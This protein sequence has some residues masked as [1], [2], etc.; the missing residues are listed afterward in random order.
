MPAGLVI[1][2][3]HRTEHGPGSRVQMRPTRRTQMFLNGRERRQSDGPIIVIVQPDLRPEVWLDTNT[4]T[5]TTRPIIGMKTVMRYE[6][7]SKA[8]LCIPH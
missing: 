2:T 1:V 3:E 4:H 8:P 6:D 5:F 7:A